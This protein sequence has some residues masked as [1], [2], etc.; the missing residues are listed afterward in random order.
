MQFRKH[1]LLSFAFVFCTL[2]LNAQNAPA[3]INYQAVLRDQQGQIIADQQIRVKV[4]VNDPEANTAFYSETHR[5]T[6]NSAGIFS[7][8]VGGG[9]AEK[10]A[11][12]DIPWST[13]N[14][15]LEV[16]YD[17]DN[18]GSYDITGTT[19]MLSVPYAFYA[20]RAG[21]AANSTGP[22]PNGAEGGGGD[23]MGET[24]WMLK[25]NEEVDETLMFMGSRNHAD[26]VLKTHNV[27]RMRI[28]KGIGAE[29]HDALIIL[30]EDV[31]AEKSMNIGA[32]LEVRGHTLLN[33]ELM[34]VGN[35]YLNSDLDVDG[36]ATVGKVL[37]V[38]GNVNAD[39][40][41]VFNQDLTVLD[42]LSVWGEA[43]I[44][45][46]LY[47]HHS[48][49]VDIDGDFGR[50][51]HVGNDADIDHNLNVDNDAH[52]GRD[53]DVD[54]NANIDVN[55]HVGND[56]DIDHNLNVDNDT[57]IG[58][59][60]DV[61]NSANIDV[62]V[63]IGRDLDVDH[64]VNIDNNLYVQNDAFIKGDL[65]V[66]GT[67]TFL[68]LVVERDLSVGRDADIDRNLNV[69]VDVHIGQNLDVDN[70][71]NIDNSVHIGVDLD[72]DNNVN[73]DNNLYVDNST[74]I[75]ND[76]TV[77]HN[78]TIN[79]NLYVDNS[80][81]INN[82]LT[83]NHNTTINNDLTVVN[84][85]TINNDLSVSNDV[86]VGGTLQ[87]ENPITANCR[88]VVNSCVNGDDQNMDNYP[89]LVQGGNQGIAI[90]IANGRSTANNFV[91]FFD[92]DG[93]QGRIEGQTYGELTTSFPFIWSNAMSAAQEAL[94]IA[95]AIA[96]GFQLDFGEV[97]VWSAEALVIAAD[98]IEYN[99]TITNE[100][101][102]AYESGSGDYAEWLERA[103]PAV[104]YNFGEIVG[105]R[106]GKISHTTR[107]AD[108]V[109][110]VSRSPI[111]LGNMPEAN[112][113][114]DYEKVAFM[115]QVPVRVMGRV[116][117]GDYILPSGNDD[118]YAKA[119]KPLQMRTEDY[120]RI[121]GVAWQAGEAFPMNLV[122]VAVGINTNDLADRVAQQQSAMEAMQAQMTQM[123]QQMNQVFAML[124]Q[125]APYDGVSND[126]TL[127]AVPSVL[128]APSKQ[129]ETPKFNSSAEISQ[130]LDK[131]ADLFL[132][133]F[134]KAK[135][136][137][138]AQGVD[139]NKYPEV[140]AIY[141]DPIQWIKQQNEKGYLEE[142]YQ[143]A[144]AQSRN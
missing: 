85:T 7:L 23:P 116:A 64:D 60:L 32:E 49:F 3:G 110:V 15:W 71:V 126:A 22:N 44:D 83:V 118:G 135:A 51:L 34:V 37:Y 47:V 129:A 136:K 55:L 109:M 80:T 100:V 69:D 36:N 81:T 43:K 1:L 5:V 38:K 19:R 94:A 8:V 79:N 93:M 88:L 12:K 84:N 96:C 27:E 58:N 82:D 72:I 106:A 112:R 42:D 97:A 86:Y 107:G 41:V 28:T 59:N 130:L 95:M 17:T 125:K 63:H 11:F 30:Q 122:N 137:L 68:D 90:S 45:G 132:E 18:N 98:W 10:G 120:S 31:V 13:A 25:G 26:L 70:N 128:P 87:V 56:A 57:H 75:N 134:A 39:G 46:D 99:V 127:A 40:D 4:S 73:I 89:V 92:T 21:S 142:V 133:I 77:N 52:I 14:T 139:V 50:N 119:V 66:D 115:G 117:V 48:L 65:D 144:K 113:E 101:G 20:E 114:N 67:G 9:K 61:D 24:A 78:T 131:N 121:V 6:T 91:S 29:P 123:Q 53:L 35:T 140:A 108:H 124:G 2:A 103:N 141:N 54:N 143:K 105:V 104:D 62:D 74:T 102:V 33:D 138:I 111:V 76:L 16:A